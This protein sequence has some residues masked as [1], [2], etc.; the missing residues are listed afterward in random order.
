MKHVLSIPALTINFN[1]LANGRKFYR[2]SATRPL[3]G[4]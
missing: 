4:P 2:V 1:D 3:A